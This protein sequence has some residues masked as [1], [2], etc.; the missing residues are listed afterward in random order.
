MFFPETP[1]ENMTAA[2]GEYGYPKE[3]WAK[4][5]PAEEMMLGPRK[6]LPPPAIRPPDQGRKWQT[7]AA[8]SAYLMGGLPKWQKPAGRP[9]EEPMFGGRRM[10]PEQQLPDYSTKSF[11]ERAAER[12]GEMKAAREEAKANVLPETRPT[13]HITRKPEAE[14][15]PPSMSK[16]QKLKT[17]EAEGTRSLYDAVRTLETS[18]MESAEAESTILNNIKAGHMTAVK[19]N[20]VPLTKKE[21]KALS[22]L[23]GLGGVTW[24]RG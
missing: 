24:V 22:S 21:A 7:P 23:S 11:V 9:A 5:G 13:K 20:G 3:P 14:S 12:S 19:P 17:L 4:P 8:E 6:M 1:V 2:R 18:G 16:E 10:M 15:A